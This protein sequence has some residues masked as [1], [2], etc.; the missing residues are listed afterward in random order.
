MEYKASV[1]GKK[2]GV[3]FGTVSIAGV[4]AVLCAAKLQPVLI[5]NGV[6]IDDTVLTV[7]IVAALHAG[8][9]A[10]QNWWKNWLIPLFKCW[11]KNRRK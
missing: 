8:W 3:E 7:E 2:A 11:L 1:T 6:V 5:S 10:F 9:R 4:V